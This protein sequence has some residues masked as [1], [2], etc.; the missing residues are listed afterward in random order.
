LARAGYDAV[1]ISGAAP[2]PVYLFLTDDAMEIR[3]AGDLWGLEVSAVSDRLEPLGKVACIGPAG[4]E[5]VRFAA[6]PIFMPLCKRP[7]QVIRSERQKIS[8]VYY[9][10]RYAS[11][12]AI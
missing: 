2:S 6:I 5:Q 8:I 11:F 4:E 1:V 9:S 7:I 10:G 3:P 12:S